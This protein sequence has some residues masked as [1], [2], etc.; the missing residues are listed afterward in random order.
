MLHSSKTIAALLAVAI[1]ALPAGAQ[2]TGTTGTGTTGGAVGAGVNVTSGGGSTSSTAVTDS[3]DSADITTGFSGGIGTTTITNPGAG[4]AGGGGGGGKGGTTS[5][6]YVA[7]ATGVYGLSSVIVPTYGNVLG[8]GQK[9]MGTSNPA[10]GG[11]GVSTAGSSSAFGAPIFTSTTTS[12]STTGKGMTATTNTTKNGFSNTNISRVPR[13]YAAISPDFQMPPR[14]TVAQLQPD[15][16]RI[17]AQ[18]TSPSLKN[19]SSIQVVAEGNTVVLMGEVSSA[20]EREFAANLLRF[21]LRGRPLD[22]RLVVMN[23]P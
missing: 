1:Y 10:G 14:A 16:Q 15:L 18:S 17:I 20:R 11:K 7:P 2:T 21:D 4:A 13:Y 22:N 6:S 8:I 23:Q 5:S 9:V 3:G 19:K 12:I